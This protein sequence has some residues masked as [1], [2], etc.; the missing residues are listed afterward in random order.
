MTET[1]LAFS[2]AHTCAKAAD[3]A[4]LSLLNRRRVTHPPVRSTAMPHLTVTLNLLW[5]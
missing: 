2:K 1:R 5:P 4:K 3:V